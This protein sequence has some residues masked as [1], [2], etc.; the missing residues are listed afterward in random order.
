MVECAGDHTGQIMLARQGPQALAEGE[1]LAGLQQLVASITAGKFQK[2]L[3]LSLANYSK[4]WL[5]T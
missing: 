3:R 1:E 2:K 5:G 4:G